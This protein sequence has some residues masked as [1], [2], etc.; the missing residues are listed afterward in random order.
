MARQPCFPDGVLYYVCNHF[1]REM[2]Q[3]CHEPPLS[4]TPANNGFDHV[5]IHHRLILPP[6]S[7]EISDGHAEAVSALGLKSEPP[8]RARGP[9]RSLLPSNPLGASFKW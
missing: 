2:K 4:M 3:A 8:T 9:C 1:P 7:P 6:V 5:G